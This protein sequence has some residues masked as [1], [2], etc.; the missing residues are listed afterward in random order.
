[1]ES[2]SLI[3]QP[4]T[5]P[6]AAPA[7]TPPVGETPPADRSNAKPKAGRE[8]APEA[9]HRTEI[10]IREEAKKCTISTHCES[11]GTLIAISAGSNSCSKSFVCTILPVLDVQIVQVMSGGCEGPL[12]PALVT[13]IVDKEIAK[14]ESKASL[15]PDSIYYEYLETALGRQRSFFLR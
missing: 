12:V 2:T 1:V 7:E 6:R 8:A 4:D 13:W 9:R 15:S 11:P 5:A 3:R 14:L 10:K